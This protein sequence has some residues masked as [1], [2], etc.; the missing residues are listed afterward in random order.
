MMGKY[1]LL[2]SKSKLTILMVLGI[3][4]VF[5]AII[6]INLS[7]NVENTD[8][9]ESNHRNI[10]ISLI[11]GKIHINN[12][13]SAA[14]SVGICSGGGNS[15]HPYIIEDLVIDGGGVGNCIL[16][17]NSSDYFIIRNCTLFNSGPDWT[18][19]GI[20]LMNV[21][22]GQIINNTITNNKNGLYF[23]S[24]HNNLIVNNTIRGITNDMQLLFSNNN[25]IFLNNLKSNVVNLFF[26]EATNIFNSTR[27]LTYSYAGKTFKGFLGNYWR[28]Y[29]GLDTDNDG[30]G[31]ETHIFTNGDTH[32]IDYY[33]LIVT[34]ENY[35]ISEVIEEPE[36]SIPGYTFILI[37]GIISITSIALLVKLK[38]FIK[39]DRNLA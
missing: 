4:I 2:R 36:V 32:Y 29:N 12:N 16:I 6:N 35:G 26:L 25:I 7:L 27:K 34:T 13:W 15:T 20:K 21:E 22:N 37:I 5:S 3:Y 10:A 14:E 18:D 33:P 39:K 9:T 1:K 38:N 23:N 8:Q 28:G 17:G 19:A 30:I 11:S 24:S 31:D